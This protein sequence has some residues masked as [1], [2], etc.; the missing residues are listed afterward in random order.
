PKGGEVLVGRDL[1]YPFVPRTVLGDVP[2][3]TRRIDESGIMR[4]GAD[5]RALAPA[6]LVPILPSDAV[7]QGT[8]RNAHGAPVLLATVNPVRKAVVGK[9]PV[10]LPRW[11]VEV[12]RP[13][14][15]AIQRDDATAVIALD[16]DFV[17][18]RIDPKVVIVAMGIADLTESGPAVGGFNHRVGKHVD[19]VLLLRVG[20]DPGV[21]PTPVAYPVLAI[22]QAPVSAGVI[23]AEDTAMDGLDHRVDAI[24]VDR[25]HR[26]ASVAHE[27]GQTLAQAMP[28]G[29]AVGRLPQAAAGATA[30]NVPGQALIVPERRV[31]HARILWIDAQVVGTRRRADEQHLAPR[32]AAVV[33][34]VYAAIM[35]RNVGIA[36][37]G[38]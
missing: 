33:R 9:H 13:G 2:E 37:G 38:D 4:I 21:V 27:A 19:R 22:G 23:G 32:L 10:E 24:G 26:H 31:E 11:L 7:V 12:A 35:G 14:P 15:S 17:V 3:N 25:R 5:L 29:A 20:I 28:G 16:H 30:A 34:A 6:D 8:A 1:A 36:L 18:A